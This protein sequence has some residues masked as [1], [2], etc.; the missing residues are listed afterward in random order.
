ML[1]HKPGT[2]IR[3]LV[4]IDLLDGCSVCVGD[5]GIIIE[6][7]PELDMVHYNDYDYKILI[8]GCEILVFGQEIETVV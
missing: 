1:R 3:V 2:L 6:D 4:N 5:L 7:K 8:N